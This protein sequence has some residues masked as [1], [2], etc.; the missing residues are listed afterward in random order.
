MRDLTPKYAPD[1]AFM[2]MARPVP[3]ADCPLP[4]PVVQVV[5]W[6]GSDLHSL[7]VFSRGEAAQL[8]DELTRALAALSAGDAW[9]AECKAKWP[10]RDHRTL[11]EVDAEGEAA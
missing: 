2:A 11:A 7:K 4:G 9:D 1:R 5:E 10:F 6:H 3:D 8:R